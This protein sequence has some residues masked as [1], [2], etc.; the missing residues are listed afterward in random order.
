MN[1]G[2]YEIETYFVIIDSNTQARQRIIYTSQNGL[3]IFV[4]R[5]YGLVRDGYRGSNSYFKNLIFSCIKSYVVGESI[6]I[7]DNNTPSI[8]LIYFTIS[9]IKTIQRYDDYK[10]I[11]VD[12]QVEPITLEFASIFDANQAFSILNYIIQNPSLDVSI[13]GSD[14]VPP[15]IYFNEFFLGNPI[16]KDGSNESGPFNSGDADIFR[17][18]INLSDYEEP[19]SFT[20]DLIIEGL[21]YNITDNRDGDF[22]LS[23]DDISIYKDVVSI[24]N[25][26]NEINSGGLYLIKFNLA[27]ISRNQNS[28]TIIFSIVE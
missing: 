3:D 27:D 24:D 13:I 21:I 12:S 6:V 23:P 5:Y 1:L 18:D 7:N 26:V 22:S 19:V 15:T 2:K 4:E 25:S 28:T 17:V 10:I 9:E 8:P 20:K 11:I 14:I 16:L